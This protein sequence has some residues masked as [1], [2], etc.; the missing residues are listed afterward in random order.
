MFV[1]AYVLKHKLTGAALCDLLPLINVHCPVQAV[2]SSKYLFLRSLE[3]VK[4]GIEFHFYCESCNNYL[5]C[6]DAGGECE[7]CGHKWTKQENVMKGNFFIYLPIAPQ[8]KDMLETEGMSEKLNYRFIREKI[9]FDAYEDIYDGEL[10][11]QLS[12][13][14]DPLSSRS[15]ISLTL[16]CDGVPVFK[17]SN[18][19]IWPIQLL[20]NE[21]PFECRTKNVMICGLWFGEKKTLANVFLKPYVNESI[22]LSEQGFVWINA[23]TQMK[24]HVVSLMFICD[25]VARPIIQNMTQFNGQF[26]CGYCLQEGKQVLKGRGSARVYP[27]ENAPLR[28]SNATFEHAEEGMLCGKPVFG[29][30]GP[31]ALMNVPYFDVIHGCPPDYMHAICLGIARQAASLW[32]DSPNHD[33]PW[34]VGLRINELDSRL[35][36]IT[37]PDTIPRLPR[38]LTARK[39]WKANEWRNWVLF[40][41]PVVLKGILGNPFYQHW[42]LLVELTFILLKESVT[43]SDVLHCEEVAVHFISQFEQLYGK[44]NVTMNV[45][46]C[47]HLVSSVKNWGPLWAHSAFVFESF[48]G[49]I[50][51]MFHG[52]QAV[53]VQIMKTF[54]YQRALPKLKRLY[55]PNPS[56]FCETLYG[57][58]IGINK[59]KTVEYIGSNVGIGSYKIMPAEGE[60]WLALKEKCNVVSGAMLKRYVRMIIGGKLYCSIAYDRVTKRNSY[61]V[62][63][64]NGKVAGIQYFLLPDGSTTCYA[65]AKIY[66]KANVPQLARDPLTGVKLKHIQAFHRNLEG[67]KVAIEVNLIKGKCVVMDLPSETCLYI[68]TPPHF[69][70]EE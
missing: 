63:L 7:I 26:G 42:L 66:R 21:L 57:Q 31:S 38:S 32:F 47:L 37:P 49:F 43:V 36:K 23:G 11:K 65:L 2:P 8:L 64:K 16:N 18:Y 70:A 45:H 22:V 67:R 62:L 3:T 24:S 5:D 56:P 33:R 13:E 39:F 30:K 10:Y 52:T 12:E 17:S 44:E 55:M 69:Q 53:P 60:D 68:G 29:V 41:S 34:C 14:G 54:T 48:N 28:N 50:L 25:S 20:V 6:K 19:S 15:A 58:M 46:L 59:A 9:N 4:E 61:T 35:L 51:K 40:Y 27:Y 1:L